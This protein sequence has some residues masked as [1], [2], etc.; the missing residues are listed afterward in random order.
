MTI[1]VASYIRVSTDEQAEQGISLAAQKNRIAAY[2]QAQGWSLRDCYCDDGWSGKDLNR[3]AMRKL[4]EDAK[5][6][7]FD[8]I[9]V[10]KLD[11][12]SRR[13]KDVLYLLEDVFESNKIGFKS[14]TEPFDT[15]TPFGKAAIGM[16]AVFAQLERETIVERIKIAKREAARQGLYL[17]GPLPYG[18]KYDRALKKVEINEPTADIVRFIFDEYLRSGCGYQRIAQTLT[19]RKIP[20]PGISSKDW[21]RQSIR[22]ILHNP[23]YAGFI[24]YGEDLNESKHKAIISSEKFFA[25]QKLQHVRSACTP[26]AKTSLLSGILYC[27]ECGARMRFKRVS[28]NA[29]NPKKQ[30]SYYVCYSQD[31]SSQSMIRDRNCKC[32][33]KPAESLEHAVIEAVS[34]I[35]REEELAEISVQLL[36]KRDDS[37]I[38]EKLSKTKKEYDSL[39][40]KLNKWYRSFE[41]GHISAELL[42]ERIKELQARALLIQ[43]EIVRC[44]TDLNA[45]QEKRFTTKELMPLIRNFSKIWHMATSEEQ[46]M[47]VTN[48]IHEIHVEKNN[49]IV[50]KLS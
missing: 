11:R 24:K 6:G 14:V 22:V 1:G 49:R 48:L 44:E 2:C 41:D 47:I 3:P 35:I 36:A 5:L 45:I 26:G 34:Q 7:K 15:T 18:Y 19:E 20:C 42:A 29:K 23:F 16:M 17:G 28:A 30:Q 9:I 46:R 33:Y 21:Q 38:E 32:G 50:L 4:I 12:L 10:I 13:Q 37:S 27:S 25:A 39:Q 31:G 40:A 8:H 43:M